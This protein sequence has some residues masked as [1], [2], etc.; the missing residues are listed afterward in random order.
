ML[1]IES[2]TLF[3]TFFFKITVYYF[4]RERVIFFS[5]YFIIFLVKFIVLFLIAPYTFMSFSLVW[6]NQIIHQFHVALQA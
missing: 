1:K 3:E 6:A 2:I 4:E 5:F